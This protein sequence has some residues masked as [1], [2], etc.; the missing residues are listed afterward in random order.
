MTSTKQ[1]MLFLCSTDSSKLYPN[2]TSNDFI[3]E[4]G[5]TYE[6]NGEWTVE[7]T[8]LR[9]SLDNTKT[10]QLYVY[11]DLCDSSYVKNKHLPLLGNIPVT[12]P[13]KTVEQFVN[14]YA[15][16]VVHTQLQRLRIYIKDESDTPVSFSK[17]PLYLT[18]RLKKH[19][20]ELT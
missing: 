2:N 18:L 12:S 8:E 14:P 17:E 19:G 15:I 3:V 16:K 20:G 5:Q 9:C 11:S 13:K 10:K 6:L 7:L 4:L 1:H